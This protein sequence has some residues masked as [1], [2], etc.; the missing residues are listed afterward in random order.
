MPSSV[1]P[2]CTSTPAVGTAQNATVLCLALPDGLGE[3]LADLVLIDVERR[4]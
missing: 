3:I 2:R 1:G 4:P